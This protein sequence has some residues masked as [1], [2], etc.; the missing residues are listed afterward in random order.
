MLVILW[1]GWRNRTDSIKHTIQDIL[2]YELAFVGIAVAFYWPF[3]QWF[4]TEYAS[5]ELW[6]GYRTPLID[7][8]FVFG[9]FLFVMISLLIR[10]LSPNLKAGYQNW[11]SDLK[12]RFI[13]HL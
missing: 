7:Y 6:K 1:D 2:L 11:V 4:K 5:L 9:L 10:D 3:T 12:Q 13:N 8:L